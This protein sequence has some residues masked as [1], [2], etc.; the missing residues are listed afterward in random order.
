MHHDERGFRL[1]DAHG[2]PDGSEELPPEVACLDRWRSQERDGGRAD[3]GRGG[4]P[5]ADPL[6]VEEILAGRE[7]SWYEL[8]EES[9]DLARDE[10]LVDLDDGA[11]TEAVGRQAARVA[12]AT[13]EYL[14]LVAEILARGVWADQGGRTPAHW[15]A[16]EVGVGTSTAKDHVRVAIRIR[17]LPRI[18][19]R[20]ASGRLSYTKVR[21]VTRIAVPEL[22][23]LLLDWCDVMTGAEV[24][25]TV[26]GFRRATHE[27]AVATGRDA[28]RSWRRRSNGDG[29][30]TLT[31]VAPDEEI[32]ELEQLCRQHADRDAADAA[33]EAA[34]ADGEAAG[35]D[36][37]SEGAARGR[38]PSG[39]ASAEAEADA[40][41]GAMVTSLV[42]LVACGAAG[43]GDTSGL[44]RWTLTLHA[45]VHD[46]AAADPG[47]ASAAPPGPDPDAA[48]TEASV[49]LPD[50]QVPTWSTTG[51]TRT[52]SASTLRR[53]ACEAGVALVVDG[54]DGAP[55]DAGRRRREPSARQRRALQARDRGCRF[56]GCD[57]TRHLHAHHVVH[58][59]DGGPTDLSN[60][61]TLCSHHHRFVHE[62][63]WRVT[64]AAAGTFRFTPPEGADLPSARSAPEADDDWTYDPDEDQPLR[65]THRGGDDRLD[66]HS[67]VAILHQQL[68]RARA[69]T[70]DAAA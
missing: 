63:G 42:Q 69:G 67:A 13:A 55:L 2:G 5:A 56:P 46:L 1:M 9:R 14:R 21:A 64:P 50:H 18:R 35:A 54:P 27:G 45:D 19:E 52:M 43:E 12:A 16:H 59:A 36:H 62:H 24:E 39:S 60:L 49:D 44:D 22:E 57:A 40:P 61:V 30:S 32:D 6:R 10:Q 70:E 34:D 51:R 28:G 37:G 8:L 15:L 33:G 29:T 65:P 68:R 4:T 53:L 25:R 47:P 23:P 48:S 26:R 11:L 38:E 3:T 41:R 31:L 7:A 17:S 20:F 58:W 66:L